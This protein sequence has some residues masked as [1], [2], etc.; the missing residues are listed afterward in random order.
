MP[1][2]V[3]KFDTD[4][5]ILVV[6]TNRYILIYCEIKIIMIHERS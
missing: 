4:E 2:K 1:L 3:I 5:A 6:A